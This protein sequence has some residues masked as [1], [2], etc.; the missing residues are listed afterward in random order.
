MSSSLL[1]YLQEPLDSARVP[2]DAQSRFEPKIFQTFSKNVEVVSP[3]LNDNS[4]S[5]NPYGSSSLPSTAFSRLSYIVPESDDFIILSTS[6][7]LLQGQLYEGATVASAATGA[8]GLYDPAGLFTNAMLKINGGVVEQYS[9]GM[10]AISHEARKITE[11]S[12]KHKKTLESFLVY[13]DDSQYV[14]ASALSN[15]RALAATTSATATLYGN[16]AIQ[17]RWIKYSTVQDYSTPVTTAKAV[18][19]RVPLWWLFSYLKNTPVIMLQPNLQMDFVL[20]QTGFPVVSSGDSTTPLRFIL[21][22]ADLYINKVQPPDSLRA[23]LMESYR[24]AKPIMTE[25]E[26]A[27]VYVGTS[28]A[29]NNI[30]INYT[31]ARPRPTKMVL[32]L[33]ARSS[34]MPN[35][36]TPK[37]VTKS[38]LDLTSLTITVNGRSI[39]QNGTMTMNTAASAT[40][41]SANLFNLYQQYLAACR[42]QYSDSD[43]PYIDYESFCANSMVIAASLEEVGQSISA[44]SSTI[45]EVK[46]ARTSTT[47]VFP[48]LVV[49]NKVSVALEGRIR[50]SA[51]AI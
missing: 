30:N 25:Y 32:F 43:A 3:L 16:H 36:N 13:Q 26:L 42:L 10:F 27:S 35:D 49:Y 19:L 47:E 21:T 23:A 5:L 24:L 29:T 48:L 14:T 38:T 15:E 40:A 41:N 46:I 51:S 6:Y 28:N 20:D 9:D 45:L 37:F 18:S 12:D 7:I 31:I 17:K 22:R 33:P 34:A 50:V 8:A 44:S 2:L 39:S 1:N 4:F 11:F